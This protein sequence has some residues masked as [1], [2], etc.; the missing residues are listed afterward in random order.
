MLPVLLSQQLPGLRPYFLE[1]CTDCL[2]ICISQGFFFFEEGLH[3]WKKK[4][5]FLLKH[6]SSSCQNETVSWYQ[7]ENIHAVLNA[8]KILLFQRAEA[9]SFPTTNQMVGKKVIELKILSVLLL[10][11]YS[12]LALTAVPAA[13]SLS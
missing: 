1:L 9:F 3:L 10:S 12:I 11:K 4:C 5:C 6:S 13:E 7:L 8:D 2:V